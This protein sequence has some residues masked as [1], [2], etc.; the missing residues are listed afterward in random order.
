MT[1]LFQASH[2]RH[3]DVIQL[4]L[5]RGADINGQNYVG[6]TMLHFMSWSGTHYFPVIKLLVANNADISIRNSD[7][8]NAADVASIKE[9]ADFLTNEL[10]RQNDFVL[11]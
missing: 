9:I 8:K 4:L 3:L 2:K 11:K 5:D 7:G 1:P 10:S 6:G